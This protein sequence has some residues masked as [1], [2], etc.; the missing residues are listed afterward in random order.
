MAA[1]RASFGAGADLFALVLSECSQKVNHQ[2]VGVRIVHR[3]ELHPAFHQVRNE[4][5]VAAQSVEFGD[6]QR[7]FLLPALV[8]RGQ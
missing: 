4:Y 1:C 8:E 6:Y 7:G 5:D 2:L 3:F